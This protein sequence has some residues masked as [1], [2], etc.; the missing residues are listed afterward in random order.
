[1]FVITNTVSIREDEIDFKS[2]RAQGA[3]GQKVNK[4]SCA[5]HLSF[6]IA[7][8][9]LPESYKTALFKVKDRR[10]SSD[11]SIIIKAQRYR[12]LEKN[13]EDALARLKAFILKA[14]EDKKPRRPT[15][16]SKGSQRRRMDSK[17]KHGQLKQTRKK[18]DI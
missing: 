12:S 1:M 10:V 8:S 6:N 16:P 17:T 3:G 14:T 15:K 7:S 11:G 4:T 2:I 5:I 9:S 18:I 13:R